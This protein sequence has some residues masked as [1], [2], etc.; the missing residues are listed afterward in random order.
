MGMKELYSELKKND[1]LKR[2]IGETTMPR[3]AL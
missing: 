1:N 3:L 2:R